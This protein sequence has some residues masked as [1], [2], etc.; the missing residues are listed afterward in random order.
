MVPWPSTLCQSAIN[1]ACK[2]K[3]VDKKN[4]KGDEEPT[5]VV[6]LLSVIKIVLTT[7]PED[8]AKFQPPIDES[9]VEPMTT[10]LPKRVRPNRNRNKGKKAETKDVPETSDQT[11]EDTKAV[12]ARRAKRKR[13][14]KAK[15]EAAK[16]AGETTAA[17]PSEAKKSEG[18][19]E[20]K[21]VAEDATA[22]MPST[23]ASA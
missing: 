7:E 11:K 23:E 2:F 22:A 8:K 5:E 18:E 19:I 3:V 4:G 12:K 6:R 15:K 14:R 16:E 1:F 20:K 13:N 9:M 10:S 21:A 17:P